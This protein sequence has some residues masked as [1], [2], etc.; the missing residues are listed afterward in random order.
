MDDD[1]SPGLQGFV[2]CAFVKNRNLIR[3]YGLGIRNFST[4]FGRK[5]INPALGG[6]AQ[7]TLPKP[8]QNSEF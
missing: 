2:F 6:N 1:A 8:I 5:V 7:N 4:R 3:N